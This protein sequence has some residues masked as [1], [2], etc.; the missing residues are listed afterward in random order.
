MPDP[1]SDAEAR[2]RLAALAGWERDGATIRRV[3]RFDT[4]AAGV[5]F[6]NHVAKLADA[7]DHHPDIL[8]GYRQV[9]LTLTSHDAGGLT[10]RDFELA[11]RIDAS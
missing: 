3:Y 9:T 2:E 11:A 4:Y 5:A 6:A 10:N 7:A 1:M 8:I